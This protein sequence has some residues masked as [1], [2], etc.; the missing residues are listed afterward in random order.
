VSAVMSLVSSLGRASCF[1]LL[2]FLGLLGSATCEG[3]SGEGSKVVILDSRNFDASVKNGEVWFV[4]F[5]AP[6][7]GHCKRLESTW[8]NLAH[9]LEG[10]ARV[11]KV[12]GT[13]NSA[14]AA[15]FSVRGFPSLFLIRGS[16]AVYKFE[17]NRQKDAL[18][19]F[20]E[21]GYK[22]AKTMT[23]MESPFGPLGTAKGFLIGLGTTFIDTFKSLTNEYG[24]P[25]W[26]AFMGMS[27]FGMG[28][29]FLGT[30][31]IMWLFAPSVKRKRD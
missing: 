21:E 11:A 24:L 18:Q 4:E 19:N 1:C 28:A 2:L 6:W 31:F 13:S 5:Y 20:V 7:C 14:L 8:E 26:V 30:V 17:G 27:L 10:T 16:Q 9:T 22:T 15:R 12:D 25:R 29:V 3:A 23:Y